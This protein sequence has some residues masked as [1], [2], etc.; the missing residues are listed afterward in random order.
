MPATKDGYTWTPAHGTEPG[1]LTTVGVVTPLTNLD[2]TPRQIY[3]AVVIGAGYAG[4]RAGRDLVQSGHSVIMLEARDRVGGR[5]YTV[6]SNGFMW[7]MG[8][9]WVTHEMGYLFQE[10]TRYGL[11]RDLLIT[12]QSGSKNDY[13]TLNVPGATPRRMSHEEAMKIMLGAWDKFVNVDGNNCRDICP[14]PHAQLDNISVKRGDVERVDRLSCKDRLEQIKADLSVEETGML[15]GILLHISGGTLENSSFWD[16]VRSHALM[17][18]S[19]VNFGPIWTTYKLR[20]GQSH[21]AKSMFNEAVELGLDYSFETEVKSIKEDNPSGGFFVTVTT[22]SGQA[23]RARY[24]VSTIPLN[25]LHTIQFNPPL[26]PLRQEAINIGHVNMMNKIHAEVSG[27]DLM[28]WNGMKLDNHIMFG[29][30]DGV[31]DNGNAHIVGFGTDVR[32]EFIAE[33]DPEKVEAAF[34][35]LHPMEIKRTMFHDWVTDKYSRGGPAWWRPGYMS[36]YQDELQKRHHSVYFASADWAHGW[37]AAI[38]GA[39][40]QG[41]LAALGITRSLRSRNKKVPGTQLKANL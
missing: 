19:S 31:L 11:D 28:S 2:G 29:Y 14:L 34:K 3:D 41:S 21:F 32:N 37:R 16:M 26:S 1:G 36:K 33:R 24:V 15:I 22:A 20:K 40:E 10:L 17:S 30:G 13:Y 23:F 5:T 27:S 6:E 12:H 25:V 39:L 7:E 8:G 9:T 4:L 38:D 18:W 35:N